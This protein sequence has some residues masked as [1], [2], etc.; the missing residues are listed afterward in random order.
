MRAIIFTHGRSYEYFA[1]CVHE[2]T[3]ERLMAIQSNS[4]SALRN[5]KCKMR[6]VEMGLITPLKTSIC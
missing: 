4:L 3:A 5:G 2:G 6:P 1:E